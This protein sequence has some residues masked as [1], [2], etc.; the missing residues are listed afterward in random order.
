MQAIRK[1]SLYWRLIKISRKIKEDIQATIFPYRH[2]L[3]QLPFSGAISQLLLFHSGVIWQIKENI[4]GYKL[5]H[6]TFWPKCYNNRVIVCQSFLTYFL[7]WILHCKKNL[8]TCRH[9]RHFR[10]LALLL[11]HYRNY[12]DSNPLS[13]ECN[14]LNGQIARPLC[15]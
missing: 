1:R 11:H 2:I 7:T 13:V 14:C 10:T 6:V 8:L 3:V 9:F 12:P 4:Q 5:G 15:T